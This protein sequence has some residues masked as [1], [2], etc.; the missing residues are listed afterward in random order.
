MIIDF[1]GEPTRPLAE[2]R[3]K[4][5]PLRDVAGMLRS[6]HYAAHAARTDA[7]PVDTAEAWAAAASAAFLDR[8]FAT[9]E[10]ATFLPQAKADRDALLAAFVLEKALYEIDYELNN[11]PDWVHIPLRGLLAITAP[12]RS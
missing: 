7:T 10:G 12:A 8:Y 3:A 6:F 11:R 5:S 4:R 2:R 9:A 1:E